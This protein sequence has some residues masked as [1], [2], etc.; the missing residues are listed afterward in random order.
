M[1]WHVGLAL[2]CGIGARLP[3]QNAVPAGSVA[4]IEA[5]LRGHQYGMALELARD[6]LKQR[7]NDPRILTLE[8]IACSSLGRQNEALAAFKQALKMEPNSLAALEGAAQLEFN[9]GDPGAESLLHRI[10]AL[11]P[12]DPT[13]H[14]MLA[15]IAYKR[16]DCAAAIEQFGKATDAIAQEPSALTEYGAC[17]LDTDHA[18]DAAVVLQKAS[19]IAPDDA[20]MVYNLA[21]AQQAAHLDRDALATLKPLVERASPDPDALDLAAEAHEDLEE[22]PEAVRLLRAALVAQPGALKYYMDFAALALKHSS[23]QVGL[24]IV[25]LG[26]KELPDAAPLYVARGIFHVQLDDFA[27][28][29]QDFETANRLDPRNTAATIAE[30]MA[31]IQH[32]DPRTALATIEAE[33]RRHPDDAFLQYL[34]ALAITKNGAVPGSPEFRQAMEAARKSVATKDTFIVARDL[35]AEMDLEAGAWDDAEKQSR[36]ALEE[37]PEDEKAI[38]HLI[39][40][41]KKSGKDTRGELPGLTRKL[42]SLLA[43]KRSTETTENKYKL[44][45]PAA[46]PGQGTDPS[47]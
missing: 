40:A 45:E 34:K 26:L 38:Y 35:M 13:S 30:G 21:V 3:A 32:H 17:L 33:L 16:N 31:E 44:Y 42:D 4:A 37:N 27:A 19:V 20:H 41:L 47:Q 6:A 18:T 15:D 11:Q 8:G 25:N 9:S 23:W 43:S 7:P 2:L 36:L 1:H 14:A 29:R 46:A 24:D 39:Q 5:A 12:A 28:A 22:T 10:V